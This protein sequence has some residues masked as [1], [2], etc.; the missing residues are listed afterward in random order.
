MSSA[1]VQRRPAI[2]FDVFNKLPSPIVKLRQTLCNA[3]RFRHDH[4]TEN[5]NALHPGFRL[6]QLRAPETPAQLVH[7]GD[8][9]RSRGLF[10]F[11]LRT[12]ALDDLLQIPHPHCYVEPVQD[13]CRR[14]RQSTSDRLQAIGTIGDERQIWLIASGCRFYKGGEPLH[15][16]TISGNRFL[17]NANTREVWSLALRCPLEPQSSSILIY[18]APERIL[19]R[20]SASTPFVTS[21]RDMLPAEQ[22]RLARPAARSTLFR[23]VT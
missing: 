12:H 22:P 23:T 2:C 8:Q 14:K 19:R 5:Q 6:L 4:P 10:C 16:S 17:T 3:W 18:G 20:W 11:R 1:V 9:L 7:A 13:R 15:S 21:W